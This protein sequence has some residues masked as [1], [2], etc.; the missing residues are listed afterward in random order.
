M[1]TRALFVAA[2]AG[3][4]AACAT[5]V[6]LGPEAT[7]RDADA[8]TGSLDAADDTSPGA[9]DV[10]S[11]EAG[12][13][14]G[15]RDAPL[16]QDAPY[17]CGLPPAPNVACNAC[18]EQNCCSLGIM[19]AQSARCAEGMAKLLDCVYDTTCVGQV[20]SEYADAGVVQYQTCVLG[21]CISQCF[22]KTICSMLARCCKDI[23]ADQLAAKDTCTG[24]VNQLD[25]S[26]CQNILDNV[27]RPQLGSQFCGGGSSDAGGE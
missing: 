13:T 1:V 5:L 16:G 26:N 23:P 14:D 11:P 12:T 17:A 24:A 22:P 15:G 21:H 20:D 4:I 10:D 25:E 19:C 27:L 18:D 6:D 9:G 2:V 3:S 8:A 7:L